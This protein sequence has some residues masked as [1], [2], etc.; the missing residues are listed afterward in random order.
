MPLSAASLIVNRL[1]S[2]NFDLAL[3]CLLIASLYRALYS[4]TAEEA[5][6]KDRARALDP[7]HVLGCRQLADLSKWYS[8]REIAVNMASSKCCFCGKQTEFFAYLSCSRCC[9]SCYSISPHTRICRLDFA[10]VNNELDAVFIRANRQFCSL[11][12]Q[13]SSTNI[14]LISSLLY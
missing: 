4:Q 2:T 1:R 12:I 9:Q 8:H 10:K 11:C 7:R 5:H 6:Y 13:C 3:M 14:S